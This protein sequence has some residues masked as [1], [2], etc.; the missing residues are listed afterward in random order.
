LTGW[1]GRAAF[2]AREPIADEYRE[3][4]EWEALPRV[5]PW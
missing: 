3:D 5:T 1:K 2:V 4:V